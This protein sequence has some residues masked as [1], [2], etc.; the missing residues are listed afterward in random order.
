[1]VVCLSNGVWQKHGV[2]GDDTG[3]FWN[4]GR[5]PSEWSIKRRG[6]QAYRGCSIAMVD[7][8]RSTSLPYSFGSA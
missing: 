3:R 8:T 2:D 1:M 5:L 4:P 7:T 6:E